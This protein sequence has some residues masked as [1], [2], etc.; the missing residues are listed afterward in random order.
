MK[1][2][3]VHRE[4]ANYLAFPSFQIT[5]DG[6]VY[7]VFRSA[8]GKKSKTHINTRSIAMLKRSLDGG[9]NW[10]MLSSIT[11]MIDYA[12]VQDPALTISENGDL[13]LSYFVWA[14]HTGKHTKKRRNVR[15]Q[16]LFI[17]YSSTGRENW[18]MQERKP[19][20]SALQVASSHSAIVLS[21]DFLIFCG[22]GD[23]GGGGAC[24][25]LLRSQIGELD[26]GKPKKIAHDPTG[27]LN[28]LEPCLIDCGSDHW[29]C[30]MRVEGEGK[31]HIYQ[32]HSWDR[33]ETWEAPRDTGMQGVPPHVLKLRDGRVLCTYGRRTK[34]YGIRAC[35]SYNGGLTWDTEREVVLRKDGGGWDLGYPST[36]QLR[37][38]RLLTGYYFYT[39]RDKRRRIECTVWKP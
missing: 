28:F 21:G 11:P 37:D 4:E 34:P 14:S 24:C 12:G 8:P 2:Y 19:E 25:F 20:C 18:G 39:K 31:T 17:R 22:Y 5:P 33:A 3:V 36:V 7:A 15:M 32:A 13:L 16:G 6:I 29:L 23:M 27:K 26:W 38:G 9:K 30:L 1:H 35:W 10:K